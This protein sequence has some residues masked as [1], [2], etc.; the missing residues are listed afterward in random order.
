MPEQLR[1]FIEEV[2][3]N[4]EIPS[5]DEATVEHAIITPLLNHLGWSI[6]NTNGIKFRYAVGK[7][8][9]DYALIVNGKPQIFVEVKR[10]ERQFNADEKKQILNYAIFQGVDLAILTNGIIWWFYLP[11]LKGKW[12]ERKFDTI[13]INQQGLDE[14]VSKFSDYLEKD[15]IKSGEAIKKANKIYERQQKEKVILETLPKAWDKIVNEPDELLVDLV[16]D[17][18]EKLCGYKPDDEQIKEFI[19]EKVRTQPS[20]DVDISSKMYRHTPVITMGNEII[21][22]KGRH[23]TN[24]IFE[25]IYKSKKIAREEA[26]NEICKKFGNIFKQKYYQFID[27]SGLSRWQHRIDSIITKKR[28]QGFIKIVEETETGVWELTD[29]GKKLIE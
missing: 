20:V 12:D 2:R 4:S 19:K 16:K 14:V 23:L 29:K 6:S 28:K 3:N 1:K 15:N 8:K 27:G 5:Y 22:I 10:S 24:A 18:T 13:N 7:D 21:K 25:V 26:M 11:N 9:V 17:K